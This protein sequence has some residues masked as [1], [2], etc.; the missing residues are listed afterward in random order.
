MMKTKLALKRK[1]RINF[2][3]F[4]LMHILGVAV[5]AAPRSY[6]E[7]VHQWFAQ[8]EKNP[9]AVEVTHWA[10]LV[11]SLR[12]GDTTNFTHQDLYCGQKRAF[13]HRYAAQ[14]LQKLLE[15][16]SKEHPGNLLV[17]WDAARPPI[18]QY[19]LWE[20]VK[21]T[22]LNAYVANPRKGSLHNL[23]MALDISAAKPDSTLLDMG[24]F[25]DFSD[26]AWAT[27]AQEELLL[28]QGKLTLRQIKNR[29]IFRD[30]CRKAGWIQLP[31]EW[32]HFNALPSQKALGVFPSL[33]RTK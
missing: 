3:I 11:V 13:L 6:C 14:K 30:L 1:M 32:W 16:I 26:K 2:Q 18:V 15:I 10:G 5:F 8:V 31:Q 4:F 19:K 28:K 29:R 17:I 20:Q 22:P 25:D 12:Y 24:G 21:G 9:Q 7:Q 23:G 33:D 27:H